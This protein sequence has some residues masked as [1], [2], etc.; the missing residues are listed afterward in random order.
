MERIKNEATAK[1]ADQVI[2]AAQALE[3]AALDLRRAAK[4]LRAEG[5]FAS[6]PGDPVDLQRMH[7]RYDAKRAAEQALRELGASD[8]VY[9]IERE[10]DPEAT[11]T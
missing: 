9:L 6:E 11:I 5:V 1:L 3:R 2:G 8:R 4:A 7:R 10:Y